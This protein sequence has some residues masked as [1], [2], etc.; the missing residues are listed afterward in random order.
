MGNTIIMLYTMK[1]CPL[2][3]KAKEL[4][5]LWGYNYYALDIEPYIK[6]KY[7]YVVI[8]NNTYEYTELVDMIAK[9]KI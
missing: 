4:L 8:G 2:C 5:E 3:D 6:R 1:N 9:G 7:P